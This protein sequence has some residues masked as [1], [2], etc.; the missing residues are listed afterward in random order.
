MNAHNVLI[1]ARSLIDHPNKWIKGNY[2]KDK[3]GVIVAVADRYA[4]C[5][6][7]KGAIIKTSSWDD[8]VQ[9]EDDL[10]EA[11]RLVT[12]GVFTSIILFNDHPQ[13]THDQILKVFDKAI[14]ISR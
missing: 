13:T 6:C 14:E 12:D 1:A 2:A 8:I 11:T 10:N 4:V 9:V 5:F 3:N 7:S